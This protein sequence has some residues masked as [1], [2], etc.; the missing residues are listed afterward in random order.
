MTTN[1]SLQSQAAEKFPEEIGAR[2]IAFKDR[3]DSLAADHVALTNEARHIGR[4]VQ[5][6]CAHEQLTLGFFEARR[7]SLPPAVTFEMLKTF[8]SI[9]SRLGNKPAAVIADCRR[10]WQQEFQAVGLLQIPERSGPQVRHVVSPFVEFV[11]HLGATRGVLA[12][13]NRDEPF[14][15]WSAETR[16]A[17]RG[18]L[19][20]L[21]DFYE[22]LAA[23]PP[24]GLGSSRQPL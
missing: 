4:L 12:R 2:I 19:R 9:A 23:Q 6:W 1:Q 24:P 15:N 22:A 16:E 10:S 5:A 14:Q 13:W 11:N 7:Q 20:P 3:A 18:Q 8:A 17:V 21:V